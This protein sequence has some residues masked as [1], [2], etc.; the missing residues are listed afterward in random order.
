VVAGD[1]VGMFQGRASALALLFLLAGS[2]QVRVVAFA[3]LYYFV[4]FDCI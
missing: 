3:Y 1:P 4:S 2:A